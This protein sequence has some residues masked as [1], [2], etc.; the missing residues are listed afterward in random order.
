MA[1]VAEAGFGAAPAVDTIKG[2]RSVV[3]R[4]IPAQILYINDWGV[5]LQTSTGSVV[6]DLLPDRRT[7]LF[8]LML[9]LF[10]CS[11]SGRQQPAGERG[12]LGPLP[13]LGLLYRAHLYD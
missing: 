13:D 11:R 3:P 5:E 8:G 4:R 2:G 9:F 6:I 7:F 1:A 10:I 12:V